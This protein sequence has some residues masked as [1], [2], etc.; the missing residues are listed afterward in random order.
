VRVEHWKAIGRGCGS[1]RRVTACREACA[2]VPRGCFQ[3]E[4]TIEVSTAG[5]PSWLV[6]WGWAFQNACAE[7]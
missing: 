3:K 6:E 1:L 7:L 5:Y 2:R 4:T